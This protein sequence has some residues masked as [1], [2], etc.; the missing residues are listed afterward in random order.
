MIRVKGTELFMIVDSKLS[1]VQCVSNISGL[2][3]NMSLRGRAT[4][5][6]D[7]N[8]EEPA[9]P[10]FSEVSFTARL[11]YATALLLEIQRARKKVT[12]IVGL[13]DSKAQPT[14]AGSTITLPTSR[15]WFT[16][17]GMF[18]NFGITITPQGIV[19]S[20]INFKVNSTLGVEVA[21]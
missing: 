4:L 2:Q 9:F 20:P 12:L 18:S 19:E 15:S 3:E 7:V 6:D 17:D 11:N 21:V 16:V 5:C 8:F 10:E 13:G 1:K 14:L